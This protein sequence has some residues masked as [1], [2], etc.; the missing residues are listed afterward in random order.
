MIRHILLAL[1]PATVFIAF[2]TACLAMRSEVT[3]NYYLYAAPH[4]NRTRQDGEGVPDISERVFGSCRIGTADADGKFLWRCAGPEL[5]IN[6]RTSA[7]QVTAGEKVNAPLR[8][9][10]MYPLPSNR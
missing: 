10:A 8:W 5:P 3:L 2:T 9:A 7:T 4:Q 1:I 6:A